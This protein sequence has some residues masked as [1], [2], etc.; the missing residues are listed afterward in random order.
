MNTWVCRACGFGPCQLESPT[1]APEA[2]PYPSMGT[3]ASWL[4]EPADD[5]APG[6]NPNRLR[7]SEVGEGY[8][9][10]RPDELG[11]PDLVDPEAWDPTK[12]KWESALIRVGPRKKVIHGRVRGNSPPLDLPGARMNLYKCTACDHGPCY[13]EIPATP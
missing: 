9:L 3:Y 5:I 13:L 1:D 8:R 6:H 11:R 2:C 12:S 4:L 10:L 7:V